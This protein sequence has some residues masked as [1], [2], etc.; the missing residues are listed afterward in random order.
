MH[1]LQ[2]KFLNLVASLVSACLLVHVHVH[3]N[4]CES[5]PGSW[6]APPT[7]DMAQ[8]SEPRTGD[9]G[10]FVCRVCSTAEML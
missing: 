7:R 9:S 6:Q 1:V 3:V 4:A 2:I 8:C 10:L 5:L